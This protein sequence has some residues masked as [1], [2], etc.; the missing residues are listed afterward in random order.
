MHAVLHWNIAMAI[1]MT[2]KEGVFFAIV[3]FV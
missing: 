3:I 1:E 2:S